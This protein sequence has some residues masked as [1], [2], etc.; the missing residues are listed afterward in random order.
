MPFSFRLVNY[1]LAGQRVQQSPPQKDFCSP[2]APQELLIEKRTLK[3]VG[4]I[5]EKV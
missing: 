5:G 2:P 1:A 4:L 3:G